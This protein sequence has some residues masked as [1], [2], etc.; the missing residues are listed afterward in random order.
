M[1][2][3]VAIFDPQGNLLV[4]GRWTRARCGKERNL[5][6]I[7]FCTLIS[8]ASIGTVTDPTIRPVRRLEFARF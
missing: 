4:R 3:L 2:G 5:C 7:C 8:A 6:R 1:S